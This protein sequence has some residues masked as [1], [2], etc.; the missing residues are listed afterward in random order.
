[1]CKCMENCVLNWFE[2]FCVW[3]VVE[4]DNWLNWKDEL[5]DLVGEFPFRVPARLSKPSQAL[6]FQ[7]HL[8]SY[9]SISKL[10]QWL[11]NCL[12]TSPVLPIFFWNFLDGSTRSCNLVNRIW[13][14]TLWVWILLICPTLSQQVLGWISKHD[15]TRQTYSASRLANPIG[16]I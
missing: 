9:C 12:S 4:A 14:F 16:E 10:I 11:A 1:M 5:A 6:K 2:I 8:E 3:L 7:D 13:W 15:L